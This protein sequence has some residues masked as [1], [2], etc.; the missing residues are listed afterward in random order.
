MQGTLRM[1]VSSWMPPESVSTTFAE[2]ISY[3]KHGVRP[4]LQNRR[5]EGLY[6]LSSLD[7]V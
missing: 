3:H 6:N 7:G 1:V 5:L 4:V 2:D